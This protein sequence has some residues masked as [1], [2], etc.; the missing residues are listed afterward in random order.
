MD[1]ENDT[2]KSIDTTAESQSAS[3][4]DDAAIQPEQDNTDSNEDEEDTP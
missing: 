1:I 4:V 2:E 3:S